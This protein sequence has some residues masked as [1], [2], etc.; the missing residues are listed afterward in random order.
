MMVEAVTF[1]SWFIVWI[2]LGIQN[3]L[4]KL[5]IQVL[6]FSHWLL[7][8]SR[9]LNSDT[10]VGMADISSIFVGFV[11]L[12]CFYKTTLLSS[13][14]NPWSVYVPR[15]LCCKLIVFK[16]LICRAILIGHT[17]WWRNIL[18]C[19]DFGTLPHL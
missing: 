18:S 13:T 19:T 14:E 2:K 16:I 9:C 6:A 1:K 7:I 3:L 15:E 12:V 5:N 11:L 4:G 17:P 10:D 8:E